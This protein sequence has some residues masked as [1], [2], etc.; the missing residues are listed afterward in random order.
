MRDAIH[1]NGAKNGVADALSR[2]GKRHADVSEDE[3]LDDYFQARMCSIVG[4]PLA[5]NLE[6]ELDNT[7]RC[8]AGE[9]YMRKSVSGGVK[10]RGR[11]I[12]PHNTIQTF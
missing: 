9:F 8:I 12:I 4:Q 6:R 5:R 7:L 1:V 2:R 10:E 11:F 3:D